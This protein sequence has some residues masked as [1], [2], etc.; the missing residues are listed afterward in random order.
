MS[1]LRPPKQLN[2]YFP[3]FLLSVFRARLTPRTDIFK[4]NNPT[5]LPDNMPLS[6]NKGRLFL[7]KKQ[8]KKY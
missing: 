6:T 5:L 8:V 7:R 1:T 2:V 4:E 3:P